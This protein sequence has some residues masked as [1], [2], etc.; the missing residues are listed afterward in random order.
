MN[1]L[2]TPTVPTPARI[3]IVM[4][5]W[6]R[7][8]AEKALARFREEAAPLWQRFDLR[9]ERALSSMGKGQLVGTNPHEPPEVMQLV[10]FP[11]LAAFQAYASDPD[12]LRLAA[13]RDTHLRRMTAV[14]G[15]PLD[16][17]SLQPSSASVPSKR[18]YGAA[19]IRFQPGGAAGFAEFN[20][21]ASALFTRHGMHVE[22]MLDVVKTVTPVGDPVPELV[23]ERVVLFFL[24]DPSALRAYA[25]DPEYQELAPVR[26]RGLLAYDFFL[27]KVPE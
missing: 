14:I 1:S 25:A 16:V 10:S 6:L 4:L 3:Y 15:T 13:A 21:R 24:D 22:A 2:A 27:G 18:L 5:S 7:P 11:S 9:V 19:F 20:Q 23:P 8:G 12:Y 17:S 26:D